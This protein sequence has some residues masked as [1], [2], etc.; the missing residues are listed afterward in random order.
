MDGPQL[1]DNPITIAQIALP[2]PAFM[3]S[4]H[5]T[6]ETAAPRR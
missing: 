4:L 2:A 6:R 5:K 1:M 3:D